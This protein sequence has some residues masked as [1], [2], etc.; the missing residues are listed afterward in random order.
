[1]NK[2]LILS[3]VICLSVAITTRDQSNVREESHFLDG[4]LCKKSG[5]FVCGFVNKDC[6]K[7]GCDSKV[8]GLNEECI[9]GEHL[10]L[11]QAPDCK[12]LCAKSDGTLFKK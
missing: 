8:F 1:M 6:C 10:D 11:S 12:E 2:F 5:G 3:L 7:I 4:E 9:K